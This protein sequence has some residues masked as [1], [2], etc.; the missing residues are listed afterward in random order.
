VRD[1]RDDGSAIVGAFW[2]I[3]I[4]SPFYILLA[5]AVKKVMGW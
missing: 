2:G 1:E 3:L 5:F 4:V